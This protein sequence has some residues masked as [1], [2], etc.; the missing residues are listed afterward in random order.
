MS[1]A[2]ARSPARDGLACCP[3]RPPASSA[4]TAELAGITSL[5]ET[6]RMVT[7]VGPA[8]VGKTRLS[9]RAAALAADQ[10][11]DGVWL[12]DLGGISDPGRSAERVA[13]ALGLPART[14]RAWPPSS[15]T[16][17]ARGCC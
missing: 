2:E 12:A 14:T 5:L 10:F 4:A 13:A 7:V 9:L 17:A 3:R 1:S 6:A 8:G 11:P 16:C 15:A